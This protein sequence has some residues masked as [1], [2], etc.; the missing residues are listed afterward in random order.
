MTDAIMR[1]D[2]RQN[3]LHW[4]RQGLKK[5]SHRWPVVFNKPAE[6]KESEDSLLQVTRGT[7]PCKHDFRPGASK[8]TGT[9]PCLKPPHLIEAL[10]KSAWELALPRCSR[11]SRASWTLLQMNGLSQCPR[12]SMLDTVIHHEMKDNGFWHHST[13][14]S[15]KVGLGFRKSPC[16]PASGTVMQQAVRQI[17]Q[18]QRTTSDPCCVVFRTLR[19][20]EP[21][22]TWFLTLWV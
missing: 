13:L 10:R 16:L 12:S 2:S 8:L 1:K 22:G 18:H 20:T 3:V 19:P 11:S 15:L 6:G 21:T 5:H 17:Q 9:L 4:Q 14:S 7:W